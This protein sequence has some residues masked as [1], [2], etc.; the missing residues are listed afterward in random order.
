MNDSEAKSSGKYYK[1]HYSDY[2]AAVIDHEMLCGD[3]N[4]ELLFHTLNPSYM[5]E[6]ILKKEMKQALFFG[7]EEKEVEKAFDM[8]K[9]RIRDDK[10]IVSKKWVEKY[11]RKI[12]NKL[13]T[14]TISDEASGES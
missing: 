13:E 10:E 2:L 12:R 5:T 14:E 6:R 8:L 3:F 11:Y 4:I 1:C 7:V 9:C